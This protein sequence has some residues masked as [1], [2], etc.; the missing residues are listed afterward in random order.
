[1]MYK[2]EKGSNYVIS[3]NL[4]TALTM[5]KYDLNLKHVPTDFCG[6]VVLPDVFKKKYFGSFVFSLVIEGKPSIGMTSVCYEQGYKKDEIN[7]E[8]R[9]LVPGY[10]VIPLDHIAYSDAV[11]DLTSDE[12]VEAQIKK[13]KYWMEMDETDAL[14]YRT[15][16]QAIVYIKNADEKFV[17][18]VNQFSSKKS[19]REGEKKVYSSLPF[20]RVG[21]NFNLP[22]QYSVDHTIV[23]GHFRWQPYGSEKTLV[24]LIYIEPHLRTYDT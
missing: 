23:S 9:T 15:L 5:T 20:I 10:H 18:E 17:S 21:M 14:Y 22:K 7:F 1:M 11:D 3:K 19:K 12:E 2:R 4:G 16:M 8:G 24:K 6:F 13:N